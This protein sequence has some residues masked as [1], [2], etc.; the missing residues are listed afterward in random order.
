MNLL[1]FELS[2]TSG[3]LAVF[4]DGQL[5][6]E[7]QWTEQPRQHQMLFDSVEKILKDCDLTPADVELYA[8]GRGPGNY[9]GLRMSIAAAQ[10]MAL[11]GGNR[12]HCVDSGVALA[13]SFKP[14]SRTA[15][16]G[17][18]RRGLLWVGLVDAAGSLAADWELVP[19]ENLS[20]WLEQHGGVDQLISPD[21]ARLAEQIPALGLGSVWHDAP[22]VPN[23]T[24]IAKLASEQI[25]SGVASLPEVPLYLQPPV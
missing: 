25:A 7:I 13:G 9:T 8:V 14:G 3:S 12:V 11:P 6:S 16:L 20:D 4:R 2:T 10:A 5:A 17:D 19:A 24:Q 23:A 22:V 21:H 18:A 1:A 15:V